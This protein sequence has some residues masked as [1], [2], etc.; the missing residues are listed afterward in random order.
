[1]TA[2]PGSDHAD[3]QIVTIDC[4]PISDLSDEQLDDGAVAMH[5]ALDK[6]H[7]EERV[8][9]AAWPD[10]ISHRRPLIPEE[11]STYTLWSSIRTNR[12]NVAFSARRRTPPAR[13]A[14]R[15][16][17]RRR[18]STPSRAGPDDPGEPEPPQP[19]AVHHRRAPA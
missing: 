2:E 13:A 4:R 14:A 3:K 17:S 10:R 8:T 6:L 15:R 1:M 18:T 19:G 16:P 11:K 12:G 7:D 5:V 9:R